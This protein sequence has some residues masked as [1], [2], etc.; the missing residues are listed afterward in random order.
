[1]NWSLL[2]LVSEW[3]IRVAMLIY[4]PQRRSAAA[5]R[6]WL[7][8]IF[9]LPWPGLL[10]YAVFGRIDLPK[11]RIERQERAARHIRD[12]QEQMSE[13]SLMEPVIPQNLRPSLD[14]ARRLSCFNVFGGNHVELLTDYEGTIDRLVDDIDHAEHHV[15]LLFYIFGVD[16]TSRRV[17]DAMV[18]AEKRGVNARVLMDAVGSKQALRRLAPDM[19]GQGIEVY[20]LL[21][22]GLLRRNAARFDLRNHRKIAVIDGKIGY[23]GSQN[24]VDAEFVK[25]YP[26]EELMARL[27]GPAVAQ[28]QAVLLADYYFEKGRNLKDPGFFP[29]IEHA[30]TTAAQLVPSGPGYDREHG[31]E[32]IV[33]MLHGAQERVVITTP[34]FV[35][36]EPF[37]HALRAAARRGVEVHLVVSQHANQMITQLAQR[38]FYEELLDSQI[39]IHLYQPRFLHAKHLTIDD[40]IALVGSTNIDIRSFA[41][42][43]EINLVLYDSRVVCGLRAVQENYFAH[44]EQLDAKA[45]KRRPLRTKVAQNIA[46]LMDS[47][48]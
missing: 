28:L 42:N 26:N 9:I 33:S 43:A 34:Y 38:S 30:G 11:R 22:V 45:W 16:R 35:P 48:L 24:I 36:D 29:R 4:V 46:R 25:G 14:L 44:S 2:Y 18:R 17:M 12:A 19:R 15:H 47:L 13:H 41:L 5:S 20:E 23:T 3:M 31:Q 21:P 27:S 39:A 6:T 40:S 37:L 8:F 32:L 7:L 1:M 10:L